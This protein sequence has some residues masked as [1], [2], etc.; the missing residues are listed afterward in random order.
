PDKVKYVKEAV[1][2]KDS[3]PL[4][5]DLKP[6]SYYFE[7]LIWTSY[8]YS[9]LKNFFYAM[10][11]LNFTYFLLILV[12]IFAAVKLISLKAKRII[13][14][15]IISLLGFTGMCVQLIVIYTFQSLHG[16][17]YQIIGLLT[18][19][20]IAGLAMGSF[21]IYRQYD[22]IK[23]PLRMLKNLLWLLLLNIAMIFIL[24]KIFPLPLAS[25]LVS[26][27]IGAAFPLAVKIH[28]KYRSE[29]GSLA[30]ILYGSDLLGGALAA[31]ITTI[32]F[33]PIFGIL[34]TFGVA[35]TLAAAALVMSYS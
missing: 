7:L 4:N 9:P 31:I 1:S 22:Q 3:T 5:T 6:I 34:N 26:L 13:L 25:F 35:I 2:F 32:L 12:A 8:F 33:I 17:V 16:Y 10:M 14:P 28:E 11:K 29:I 15:V 19:A 20:F 24:L 21:L 18:T 30:G 23:D 27:P